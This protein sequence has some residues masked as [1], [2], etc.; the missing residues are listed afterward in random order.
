VVVFLG[1]IG[2]GLVFPI[3][4][5]LG[6]QLGI[7]SALIGLILAANRITR[8]LSNPM[9]GQLVDRL[10]GKGPLT[11]GLLIEA[12]ATATY[13][14]ALRRA[15][16]G[17]WLLL[18]RAAWG[19]GS[20]FLIVG[21]LT[22]ALNLSQREDRGRVTSLVRT[23]QSLGMPAG[24]VLGGVIAGLWSDDAAFLS[25]TL[26]ALCAAAVTVAFVPGRSRA[27]PESPQVRHASQGWATLLR[28][29]DRRIAGVWILNFLTFFTLQGVLITTF[30]LVVQ[31][32]GMSLFGLGSEPTAGLLMAF[33]LAWSA[34]VTVLTGKLLDRLPQRSGIVLPAL[35]VLAVGFA[36]LAD[37]RSLP[38]TLLSLAAFGAAMGGISIPLIA[39][40]GDLSPPAMRGRAVGLFQMFGDGGGSLGPIVG[41]WAGLH[42]GFTVTYTA[43]AVFVLACLPL[44]AGLWVIERRT[45][46]P[47]R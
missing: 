45:G 9:T 11:V 23:A 15:D 2:G 40:V 12:T 13:S 46:A 30:V 17:V 8:L 22:A 43:L 14:L 44:A 28:A 10:G 25:A 3:L 27:R 16:P 5:I 4:P 19:I 34:G 26:L 6:V 31:R 24:L 32:R 1:G 18:G 38:M 41:V 36:L 42:L 29:A 33:M 7:S 37:A 20:S 47:V 21:A 39:I 35:G